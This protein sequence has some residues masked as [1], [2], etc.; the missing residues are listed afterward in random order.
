M[1]WNDPAAVRE[2]LLQVLCK[3]QWPTNEHKHAK[4]TFLTKKRNNVQIWRMA[5]TR[6]R[7]DNGTNFTWKNWA[8]SFHSNSC[9]L[10]SV[11]SCDPLLFEMQTKNFLVCHIVIENIESILP[12]N[13][14]RK[15]TT[16]LFTLGAHPFDQVVGPDHI[17]RNFI[18]SHA[19][20]QHWW[21][22]N[23]QLTTICK[24]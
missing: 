23:Q 11:T 10:T 6:R 21:I 4:T 15:R 8:F 18:R 2:I 20:H 13:E 5:F 19:E 17:P 24:M 16:Y 14:N 7:Q 12:Q 1:S 3:L 22:F 9:S